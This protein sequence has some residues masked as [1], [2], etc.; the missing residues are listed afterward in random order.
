MIEYVGFD[1]S[2]EETPFCVKD[3]AGMVL[4]PGNAFASFRSTISKPS[5]NQS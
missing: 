4:A 3:T 2:K 1:V 5:A